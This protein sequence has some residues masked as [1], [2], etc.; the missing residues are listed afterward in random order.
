MTNNSV[1]VRFAPSPTGFMH[2]GN[3][4]AALI[5]YIFAKQ[6]K[7]T[8]ILRIEDTDKERMIDPEGKQII[9]DLQW[10]G[11]TYDEG[12]IKG[13]PYEPYCQSQRQAI[14]QTHLEILKSKNAVYRCFC[15]PEE[16]ETKRKRQIAL[17]LPPRYD[18]ACLALSKEHHATLCTNNTPFIWR[19]QLNHASSVDFYDLAHKN[20]HFQLSHFSDIP[21]TRQDG[22][23]TFMFANFV[24][25]MTMHITHVFR[26]ED[27]LSNTA[28]QVAL[29]QAFEAPLPL[30]YHLPIL[31]TQEGR[32]L[33]K[34]DFGF[35]LTDLKNAGYIPEAINNYL[36]IIG[37]SFE[38]E[39][40][41]LYT[42]ISVFNFE[43]LSSTG[44]ITY[45]LEKL[46]WINHQWLMRYPISKLVAL[47]R[48]YLEAS[49]TQATKL[50]D[51][52]LTQIIKP[53]QQELVTIK[54]CVQALEF[55][56]T[57]P[58][59]S[60][61]LLDTYHINNYKPFLAILI[62][63]LLALLSNPEQATKSAQQLC[64]EHKAPIKDIFTILR[65]AL[66][67]KAQGPS[68]KDIVTV[69]TEKQSQE[70]LVRLL[71]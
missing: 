67:G 57:E 42:L 11:L 36:G 38:Q 22:S 50:T 63:D 28:G 1:R 71:N 14:Y 15:S 52:Q 54:E 33:S 25:D 49:Y 55:Y 34:R 45:D 61:E 19:F 39:I 51:E 70:R 56:F 13:G 12:P 8:L 41:T 6:N 29:Y 18:R 9:S 20:M 4:R 68:I 7:G 53:V 40:M 5:N 31:V 59:L 16:L 62:P 2:L 58:T 47:S 23:F 64:K 27:H 26:G 35:S 60:Q 46:R 44:P 30:F 43:D 32:K 66:T 69:L 17:K 21:I 3:V 65:I 24:D 48:P 10:L 37:K